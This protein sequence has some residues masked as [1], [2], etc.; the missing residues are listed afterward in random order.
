MHAVEGQFEVKK[1]NK[2]KKPKLQ[3]I[4]VYNIYNINVKH[5]FLNIFP[6]NT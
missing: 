2:K 4:N 3:I 1:T 5:F 6:T